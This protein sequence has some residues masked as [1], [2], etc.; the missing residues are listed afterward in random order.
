MS[1]SKFLLIKKN[2]IFL[3]DAWTSFNSNFKLNSNIYTY[4]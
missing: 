3:R 4:S 1:N 2:K